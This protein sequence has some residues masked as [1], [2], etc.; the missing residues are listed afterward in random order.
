MTLVSEYAHD[1]C[2]YALER[3]LHL[4]SCKMH[5]QNI[6]EFGCD[7]SPEGVTEENREETCISHYGA[8]KHRECAFTYSR[9]FWE[10][11]LMRAYLGECTCMRP[12]EDP[13]MTPEKYLD[14]K[15]N[16]KAA[17][18]NPCF[19][20]ESHHTQ[21]LDEGSNPYNRQK[22]R[23]CMAG[24]KLCTTNMDAH[25]CGMP[26]INIS[27]NCGTDEQGN[28][29]NGN[30]RCID[31]LANFFF[32]SVD[33][34]WTKLIFTCCEHENDCYGFP[35]QVFS[36]WKCLKKN[37]FYS[38]LAVKEECDA[39]ETCKRHMDAIMNED[40]CPGAVH[41]KILNPERHDCPKILNQNCANSLNQVS[42]WYCSCENLDGYFQQRN[43]TSIT[44]EQ[45][46]AAR[47]ECMIQKGI[48][49]HNECLEDHIANN[50]HTEII[51]GTVVPSSTVP[52]EE[53]DNMTKF[54]VIIFILSLCM[55][56]LAR[57]RWTRKILNLR[58]PSSRDMFMRSSDDG[59]I[60]NNSFPNSRPPPTAPDFEQ[61]RNKE[62]PLPTARI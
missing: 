38:C 24:F 27:I 5:M 40:V 51:G 42:L 22:H 55:V 45:K 26:L 35:E 56:V 34:A 57:L 60:I 21:A 15:R 54:I 13:Y 44:Q 59:R 30:G 33:P 18:E 3:C 61:L 7:F 23:E 29:V 4:D 50:P 20:P 39:I 32:D 62:M 19:R 31:A 49:T 10:K 28:C 36:P 6:S 48:F 43:M 47:K 53:G 16:W 37:P 12:S 25:D 1:D 41:Q 52:R 46:D 58:I 14:C 11:E 2:Q 9:L 8:N 17:F